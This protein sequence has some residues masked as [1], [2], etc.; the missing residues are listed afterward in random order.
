M[1]VM[2]SKIVQNWNE[3][4]QWDTC[5][6]WLDIHDDKNVLPCT[7]LCPGHMIKQEA[8][9]EEKWSCTNEEHNEGHG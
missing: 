1:A 9:N 7:R 5:H 6:K 8:E 4:Q 3:K 2:D